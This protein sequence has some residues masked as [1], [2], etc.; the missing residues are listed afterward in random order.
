MKIAQLITLAA[1]SLTGN[2]GFAFA[3]YEVGSGKAGAI[4]RCDYEI[5]NGGIYAKVQSLD[6]THL[7]V[8]LFSDRSTTPGPLAVNILQ[9]VQVIGSYEIY[10]NGDSDDFMQVI[11]SQPDSSGQRTFVG[12][13]TDKKGTYA[14]PS[15]GMFPCKAD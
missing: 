8:W 4:Y 14:I 5:S 6:K 7:Q 15:E 12:S 9:R 3:P 2:L 1:L 11:L 13:Y 10:V